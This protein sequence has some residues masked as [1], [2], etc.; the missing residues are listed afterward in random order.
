VIP[1]ETKVL[2]LLASALCFALTLI[3]APQREQRSLLEPFGAFA[4]TIQ[5]ARA[6]A[7][8][9]AGRIDVGLARAE[10]ALEL[11]P[12]AAAGWSWL[13][14]VLVH[15]FGAPE[16][17]A[18]AIARRAWVVAGVD[19]LK[20]GEG[21]SR[22]PARLAF[23]AGLIMAYVSSIPDEVL[24]WPGGSGVTWRASALHFERAKDFGH[25]RAEEAAQAAWLE[26][27]SPHTHDELE[28]DSANASAP[29]TEETSDEN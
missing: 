14:S 18:T 8:F 26:V 27:Y 20:R 25:P 17:E 28:F 12:K 15:R 3:P 13:A 29:S 1:K 2:F 23:H 11:N 10:S 5:W 21:I 4:A 22:E 6:D 24:E 16:F 7:A 9:D 19:L